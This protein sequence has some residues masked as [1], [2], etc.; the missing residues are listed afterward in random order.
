MVRNIVRVCLLSVFVLAWAQPA[1]AQWYV[2]PYV[3]K[4]FKLTHPFGEST[5]GAASD[6]P[7]AIGVSGG[8]SP[9]KRVGIEIDF[10]R[11]NNM[12][13]TGDSLPNEFGEEF[14]GPNY[15]QSVTVAAHFGHTIAGR[16]RPYGVAGGGL[17]FI[18]LGT[19]RFTD[20]D[21]DFI[22][23]R[24]PAQ[25]TVIFNCLTGLINAPIQQQ[26]TTCGV[27]LVTE[28]GDEEKGYKGLLAFGG[29][30][31]VKVAS[32]VAARA[33]IRFFKSIPEEDGGPFT[34]WRFV[35]GVVIH[36]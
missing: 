17:N 15:M 6:S 26:S 21:F 16:F 27:P 3:G 10:Q 32:H 34:F 19:E 2:S 35:A 5:V 36:R 23:S 20:L 9:F 13:R 18:N 25:Q 22:T 11:I 29:G 1:S 12:F 4:V 31:N 24:P 28:L 33:D 8:T 14:I 7:T 30:V